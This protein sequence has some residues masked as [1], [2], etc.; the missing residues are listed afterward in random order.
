MTSIWLSQKLGEKLELVQKA[1]MGPGYDSEATVLNRC[2][3]CSDSGLTWEADPRHAELVVAELGLHTS[4]ETTDEPRRR[5]TTGPRGTGIRWAKTYHSVSARLAYLASD[6]PD[7]AFACKGCSRAV[8]KAT[9]GD[10]TRLKRI[11]RDLLYL[12]LRSGSGNQ[13][14]GNEALLAEAEREEPR[15]QDREDPRHSQSRRLD[16]ETSGWPT[17]FISKAFTQYISRASRALAAVTLVKRATAKSLCILE[18]CKKRGSM[19]A[20]QMVGQSLDG[21]L[22]VL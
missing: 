6:R 14:Y 1:R 20:V 16:D 11:G 13:A 5:C 15:A 4:S 8:G 22:S 21:C 3:M 18:P 9:R 19:D 17:E 2:V 12:A 7:I 10:L